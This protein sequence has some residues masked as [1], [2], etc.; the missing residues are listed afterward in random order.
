[1]KGIPSLFLL[2]LSKLVSLSFR[3]SFIP[4]ILPVYLLFITWLCLLQLSPS[5]S[6]SLFN[7][8]FLVPLPPPPPL[9]LPLEVMLLS[10]HSSIKQ[11]ALIY[12]STTTQEVTLPD[13]PNISHGWPVG[14]S[15]TC[16]WTSICHVERKNWQ[17][18]EG[19]IRKW[20]LLGSG[21]ESKRRKEPAVVAK[22]LEIRL[23]QF[24]NLS[25]NNV[26][27][28]D[29]LLLTQKNMTNTQYARERLEKL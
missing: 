27:T 23:W 28:A 24:R 1:M 29:L 19:K 6:F 17:I 26:R 8:F 2:L 3:L 5:P 20:C 11:P 4:L 7:P 22:E 14:V 25:Q 10:V 9:C 18:S 21:N 16:I 12:V 13:F 15:D